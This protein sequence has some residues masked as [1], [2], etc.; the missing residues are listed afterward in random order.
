MSNL[1]LE[2]IEIQTA[3]MDWGLPAE[4]TVKILREKDRVEHNYLFTEIKRL[5]EENLILK[6]LM[7]KNMLSAERTILL[8]M[9]DKALMDLE[10]Q[11]NRNDLWYLVSDLYRFCGGSYTIYSENYFD[12]MI[13]KWQCKDNCIKALLGSPDMNCTEVSYQL[14]KI[15]TE[16]LRYS[17]DYDDPKYFYTYECINKLKLIIIRLFELYCKK[18]NI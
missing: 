5:R 1:N 3:L 2:E 18:N 10:K 6:N 9:Y 11:I 8:D 16:L 12:F 13:Q 7:L 15:Q 4:L 14:H 17:Y